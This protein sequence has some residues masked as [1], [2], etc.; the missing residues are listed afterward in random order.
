M[1]LES[2]IFTTNSAGIN[3]GAVYAYGSTNVIIKNTFTGNTA[4]SVS[5]CQIDYINRN[6]VSCA[7]HILCCCVVA[8]F[9]ITV[10]QH[11]YF[12]RQ[13][14]LPIGQQYLLRWRLRSQQSPDELQCHRTHP[15]PA[16]LSEHSQETLVKWIHVNYPIVLSNFKLVIVSLS[17][18][19][20]A[21]V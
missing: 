21:L 20:L 17:S 12:L 6:S 8:L 7:S 19:S 15:M 2:N 11:W 14:Y 10:W 16:A 1:L 18:M 9:Y 3:G 5:E 13:L 4:P